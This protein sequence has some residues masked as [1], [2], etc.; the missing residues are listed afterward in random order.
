MLKQSCDISVCIA[1][2]NGGDYV[3]ECI[4]SVL[5]QKCSLSVEIIVHDDC[6][7]D[8][9]CV[10]IERH[11]P[12]VQLIKSTQN[13]GFCIS[14]NRMVEQS[15]GK[16]VL[17]LNNDAALLAGALKSFSDFSAGHPDTIATLPQ[18]DAKTGE[19]LDCGMYMDLFANPIPVK[20]IKQQDVATAMGACLWI[21]KRV[22]EKVG[23]FPEWFG[24][25]AEDMYVCSA[26]RRLGG[27]VVALGE[28][29]YKHVVGHSFGG[30]KLTNERLS[31]TYKRRTL[32]ETN[33]TF[34]MISTYP[35]PSLVFLL[36]IH[37]LLLILEGIL[38]SLVKLSLRP[39]STIYWASLRGVLCNFHKAIELRRRLNKVSTGEKNR[40]F[41]GTVWTPYKLR[42]LINYGI[43]EMN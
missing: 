30:G 36:P 40:V 9:S 18:F 22:W 28:S 5:E 41:Y 8:N 1:N 20:Q 19:L 13:V 12:Q 33:K 34:V 31:T 3:I 26:W 38:L 25:I 7:T 39:L 4:R 2:Y 21:P 14:N 16:F 37:G 35:A 24:S 23:G 27:H 42:L 43:P 10:E 17:L 29:G 11:Y 15:G 6:S 32:S